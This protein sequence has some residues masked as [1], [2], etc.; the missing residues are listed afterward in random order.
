MVGFL[1]FLLSSFLTDKQR[2]QYHAGEAGVAVSI[3]I[4]LGGVLGVVCL[5]AITQM[6]SAC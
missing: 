1:L 6:D 2:R 4:L 3:I 5:L